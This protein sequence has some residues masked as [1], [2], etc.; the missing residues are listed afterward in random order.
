MSEPSDKSGRRKV[1]GPSSSVD[2]LQTESKADLP[3]EHN[4]R[5]SSGPNSEAGEQ[6]FGPNAHGSEMPA[7]LAKI[8]GSPPL[9]GDE[10]PQLYSEFFRHFVDQFKPREIT[11]WLDVNHLAH[12]QWERLRERRLKPEAIKICQEE[13]DEESNQ[14]VFVISAADARL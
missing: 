3:D 11:D 6:K 5:K 2:I 4:A 8:I 12:I 10:D 7:V 14:P 9:L 1:R 13:P